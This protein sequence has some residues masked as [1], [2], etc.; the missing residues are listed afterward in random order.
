[1]ERTDLAQFGIHVAKS[2]KSNAIVL[3]ETPNDTT[4]RVLGAG[5]GQ[6]N[7]I[8]AI[9]R[10]A[11]PRARELL[12]AEGKSATTDITQVEA[13]IRDRLNDAV[14]ISDA[15][16]P[17]SDSIA[18]CAGAEISWIVQPGGSIRDRDV[19]ASAES[20]GVKLAFTGIRH[21]RH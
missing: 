11:I 9:L 10:L 13:Y 5:Q 4:F 21:F 7:R 15:F 1:V 6:P 16:F 18:A 8:D 14:L 12:E 2:L 17:F 20:M 3:V 19:I